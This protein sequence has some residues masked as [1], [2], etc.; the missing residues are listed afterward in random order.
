MAEAALRLLQ[1]ISPA[2]Q[3]AL[4]LTVEEVSDTEDGTALRIS[5]PLAWV[6]EGL[7]GEDN[8]LEDAQLLRGAQTTTNEDMADDP[9]EP[10]PS[11]IRT[12]LQTLRHKCSA[13]KANSEGFDR[14]RHLLQRRRQ[15]SKFRR[16]AHPG[17]K[18][19][20]TALKE[21]NYVNK[22]AHYRAMLHRTEARWPSKE[23]T[24]GT[25]KRTPLPSGIAAPWC[26]LVAHQ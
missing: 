16:R 21:M 14:T 3:A 25:M 11:E 7:E 23:R 26:V 10:T 15:H 5:Q 4:G 2:D 8:N 22:S 18:Q 9:E 13:W 17:H 1:Q 19:L 6:G 12:L 20:R 24:T